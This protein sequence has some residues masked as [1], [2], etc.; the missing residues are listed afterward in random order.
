MDKIIVVCPKC[1][2]EME[3]SGEQK[4]TRIECSSC[5]VF[6]M[7]YEAVKCENCGR[8][9]HPNHPCKCPSSRNKKAGAAPSSGRARMKRSVISDLAKKAE[10]E[11][12]KEQ[13]AEAAFRSLPENIQ[14]V[15]EHEAEK[16]EK[17]LSEMRERIEELESA[18]SDLEAEIEELREE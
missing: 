2:R 7:A 11:K 4:N 1:R 17:Q 6:F 9:R 5:G 16:Y 13:A 12:A 10:E 14:T 8:F 18:V 15:F 3:I